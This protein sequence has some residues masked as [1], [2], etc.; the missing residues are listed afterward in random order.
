MKSG[1]SLEEV[2]NVRGEV[3]HKR[4]CIWYEEWYTV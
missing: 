2:Y 3:H 4:R 1:I